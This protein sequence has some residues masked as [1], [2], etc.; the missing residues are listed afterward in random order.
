M[1]H[2]YYTKGTCSR[3]IDFTLENHIVKNVRFT[4]GCN[5]NTA[6][7]SRLVE[8]MNVYDV[9]SKLKGIHCGMRPT[10]CPDQ[11]A[12]ALEEALEQES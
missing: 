1:N 3:K 8:G 2:T 7:I 12:V 10:S 6:G 9:I 5:G 4:N 11:L